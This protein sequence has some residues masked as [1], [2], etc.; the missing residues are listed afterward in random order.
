MELIVE[1]YQ[2]IKIGGWL[3]VEDRLT[4]IVG[5]AKDNCSVKDSYGS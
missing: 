5:T 4:S 3:I 1:E 2:F